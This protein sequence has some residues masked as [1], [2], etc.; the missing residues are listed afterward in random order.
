MC[1]HNFKNIAFSLATKHQLYLCHKLLD[2]NGSPAKK[3]VY[4][5]DEVGE[6]Q[7]LIITQLNTTMYNV[8]W[9]EL[10]VDE[11]FSI[12][13][14]K[15]TKVNGIK[16]TCGMVMVLNTDS[17]GIPMFGIIDNILVKD[18]KKLFFL[19]KL[20]T[21]CFLNYYNSFLVEN[22]D[23]YCL[24]NKERIKIKFPTFLYQKGNSKLVMAR[25][26]PNSFLQ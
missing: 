22:I 24:L 8:L 3:I 14:A 12:Y 9:I 26:C 2:I 25:N 7:Q 11:Y 23:E 6:G 21:N 19:Q 20:H 13:A 1:I 16:Y 17:C 18:S 5:G 4:G 10:G 15:M